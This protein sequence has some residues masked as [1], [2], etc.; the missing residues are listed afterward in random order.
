MLACWTER[1]KPA[2]LGGACCSTVLQAR[3]L[4][5][6]LPSPNAPP[7]RE[8]AQTRGATSHRF[9]R[10]SRPTAA[11]LLC[12]LAPAGKTLTVSSPGQEVIAAIPSCPRI[13]RLPCMLTLPGH[14]PTLL[15]LSPALQ[16]ARAR[17]PSRRA[18]T[19]L[20]EPTL[21]KSARAAHAR[22]PLVPSLPWLPE[23]PLFTTRRPPS[24]YCFAADPLCKCCRPRLL[25]NRNGPHE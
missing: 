19:R 2:V 7:K 18:Q 10:P 25:A 22:P 9:P 12:V 23:T 8:K 13:A 17:S 15:W 6:A 5:C 24:A 11:I 16:H 14:R 1:R 20:R 4:L 21:H 3:H